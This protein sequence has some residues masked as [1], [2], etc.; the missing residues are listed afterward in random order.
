MIQKPGFNIS[1]LKV[2]IHKLNNEEESS[3][4]VYEQLIEVKESDTTLFHEI[5]LKPLYLQQGKGDYLMQILRRAVV[6]VQSDFILK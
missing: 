2:I 1:L 5:P 4:L 3:E 6:V